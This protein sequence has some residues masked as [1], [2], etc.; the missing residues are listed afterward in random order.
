MTL[1]SGPF[2]MRFVRNAKHGVS[3]S[4]MGNGKSSG[5]AL[6]IAL[7][8]MMLM[9]VLGVGIVLSVS[10]DVLINGYYGNYRSAYYAADTGLNIVRQ[11]LATQIVN[12]AIA[13]AGNCA[14]W[15]GSTANYGCSNYPILTANVATDASNALSYVTTTY[16]ASAV[17][18]NA[19][20]SNASWPGN[21]QLSSA[22]T[23]TSY[24]TPSGTCTSCAYVFQYYLVVYGQGPLHQ[25][26]KTTENGF[27]TV[28]ISAN[29][30]GGLTNFSQFGAF[31]NNYA[32]N[33]S[34]YVSGTISGKQW[35][36]GSWNFGT[37]G[38]YT[39]TGPVFQVGAQASYDFPN[40][41][42]SCG[43]ASYCY[44]DS[45][46]SKY[47]Y[48]QQTIQPNFEQGFY[49][50]MTA[51]PLPV[52]DYNQQWAVLDGIGSGETGAASSSFPTYLRDVN[53]NAYVAGATTG[54][55]VPA[56]STGT[57]TGGGFYV[58][59]GVTSIAL[60][61]GSSSGS[62][63]YTIVQTV[64]SSAVTTTITT[65][66]SCGASGT[67]T[68]AKCT[69]CTGH[70]T[71]TLNLTGVPHN[72]ANTAQTLLYVDGTIGGSTGGWNATY[73][74][75]SGS[76]SSE[77]AAAIQNGVALTI[78]ANGD[79]N[80]V[81]NL[82]YE[83]ERVDA[84]GNYYP[85]NNLG[86]VLGLY[87]ATGNIALNSPYNDN[88]LEI[89]GAIA[90]ISSNCSNTSTCGLT[91]T[92]SIGTFTIIGGKSEGNAHSVSM[93]QANIYYDQGFLH[94]VA[95]PWFPSTT[96]TGGPP[97]APSVIPTFSRLSWSTSPQ[98]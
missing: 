90:A 79:I 85:T 60:T 1:Q 96:I 25:Q 12:D 97:N 50:G 39:F 3:S 44:E 69:S 15:G 18:L 55:Y 24:S 35:T 4:S 38:T 70:D 94:G 2:R 20:Q 98:N 40:N 82:L 72:S 61:P 66:I 29:G 62:E 37:N 93:S 33:S 52:N 65:C 91:T 54:V 23:F 88:N 34:P 71:T 5:V 46:A 21:F 45:A 43:S 10:S 28:T 76:S 86:Q 83:Q 78:V 11:Q 67:T 59:G 77:T 30:G 48:N 42:H 49:P 36:N 57:V 9:S 53:N 81:G 84:S 74:G 75:L 6:V 26:V 27:L 14:S 7:L 16:G 58:E 32:A 80:V 13:S 41:N 19:G 89:D 47:T 63:I 31:I 68:I 92:G 17:Q 73:T 8:L 95:P 87:T 56:S 64:G 51:A 22:S